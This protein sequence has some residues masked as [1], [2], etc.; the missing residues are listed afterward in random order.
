MSQVET[1][2]ADR[3][4]KLD[5]ARAKIVKDHG[6][7]ALVSLK[8][9]IGEP[10]PHISTGSLG[11]DIA[12]GIGGLPLGRIVEIYGPESSGKTTL[13]LHVIA[14]AQKLGHIVGFIDMEHAFDPTYA[15]AIGVQID[16]DKFQFS[17]PDYGEQALDI[18]EALI[19]SGVVSVVVI[20]SVAA[21]TPKAEI[22]A[23]MEKN[24]VGLQARLLSQAMR[25]LNGIAHKNNCLVIF[26]NQ[27]RDKIGVMFGSPETTTGG[28]ALKF[29]SSM[30]FDIRRI[31]QIKEVDNVAGNRAR[32]KVVKNKLAPPFK[33]CEFDIKFGEGISKAGEVL[34]LA[35]EKEIVK[36]AGAWY[37]YNESKIGQGRDNSIEVLLDNPELMQEIEAKVLEAIKLKNSE[38][39]S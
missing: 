5:A 7:Q 6:K 37:S 16:D 4:K 10:V 14:E 36:K 25:K 22:E 38:T 17:Q 26:I 32:V 33:Q 35:V 20:D 1:N 27:L 28:N 30:R 24:T 3:Q 13:T 15:N 9:R 18:A 2:I 19:N 29:Y 23:D 8:D 12:T 39:E 11:L 21:L 34:D 31:G